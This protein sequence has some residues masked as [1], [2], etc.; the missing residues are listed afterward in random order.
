MKK[1]IALIVNSLS[2]GGAEKTAA[3]LSRLLSDRYSVDIIVNDDVHLQY[4]HQ[5]RV[6]SLHM[7]EDNNR[8]NFTYQIKALF[9]RTRVLK[10]LKRKK[11]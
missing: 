10:K 8:S 3:N 11:K 4:S 1:R 2:G 5:G 9:R 6:L 7:P